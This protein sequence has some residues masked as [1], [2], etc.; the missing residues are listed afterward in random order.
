MS[1][2]VWNQGRCSSITGSSKRILHISLTF[3]DNLTGGKLTGIKQK[4]LDGMNGAKSAVTGVLDNVKSSFQSKL[5]AAHSVVSGFVGKLK[6]AFSFN[7]KLPDLKI[8]HISISGGVAPFGIAGKGS[9]PSFDIQWYAKGGVMTKPTIF[10]ASGGNLLGG[11]EAG[12]E[13][14]LPLSALWDKL[15]Q[16]I[17]EEINPDNDRDTKSVGSGIV[18]AL[19]RKKLRRLRRKTTV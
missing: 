7:W 13:A 19:S 12:D 1:R 11:G 9:L 16:F 2:T 3:I 17:Q 15:R 18:Q 6:S 8:P 5:D 10:G 4:F 14:I